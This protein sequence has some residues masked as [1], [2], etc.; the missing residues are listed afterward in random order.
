MMKKIAAFLVL[1]VLLCALTGCTG[2]PVVYVVD[3]DCPTAAPAT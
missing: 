2:T 3:C 1:A